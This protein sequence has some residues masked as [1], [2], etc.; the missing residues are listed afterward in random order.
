MNLK[1]DCVPRGGCK[2]I[3]KKV[4]QDSILR[5]AAGLPT[6]VDC[7]IAFLL[8]RLPLWQRETWWKR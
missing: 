8:H 7:M 1:R 2:R 6:D 3:Q 4:V 5:G